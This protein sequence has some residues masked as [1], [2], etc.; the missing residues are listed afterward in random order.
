VESQEKKTTSDWNVV[1]EVAL[2]V[3]RKRH[4][5]LRAMKAAFEKDDNAE[6]LRLGRELCGLEN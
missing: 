5:I 1:L 3:S 6:A 4:E 2:E